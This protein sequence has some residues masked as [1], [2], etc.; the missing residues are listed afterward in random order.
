MQLARASRSSST[1]TSV[2][3][4][5]QKI[6]ISVPEAIAVLTPPDNSASES[7]SPSRYRSISSSSAS[8]IASINDWLTSAGSIPT[9]PGTSSGRSSVLTTPENSLPMPT[10]RVSGTQLCPNVSWISPTNSSNCT[11]SMSHLLIRI[12]RPNPASPAALNARRVLTSIPAPALITTTAVSTADRAPIIWPMKSGNPGVSITCNR[13]PPWSNWMTVEVMLDLRPFSSSSVSSRLLPS[14]TEPA[15][16]ATPALKRNKS[17]RVVL[18]VAP[19]PTSATLRI[20][21]VVTSGIAVAS[22]YWGK[23]PEKRCSYRKPTAPR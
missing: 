12:I 3:E 23:L 15:R 17:A 2:F 18:P 5:V 14:S 16:D 21:C 13:L 20:F 19:C 11:L 10:G 4:L 6:G 8:T 22:C 9:S 7:S 1:P